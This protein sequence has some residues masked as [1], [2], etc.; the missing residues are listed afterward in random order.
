MS[1]KSSRTVLIMASILTWLLRLLRSTW[2][3]HYFNK[4]L[5][6]SIYTSNKKFLVCF[7]HGK[8]IPVFPLFEGY[9]VTVISNHSMRGE[10]I[11]KISKNFGY[12]VAQLSNQPNHNGFSQMTEILLH[13]R[14][15]ATPV[16]GPSGPYGKVK[17]SIILNAS[18][19]GYDLLPIAVNVHHK[20]MFN[21]RW[22]KLEV[23][24]PFSTVFLVFGEPIHL[25]DDIK[26]DELKAWTDHV[27][28]TMI[29]LD[30]LAKN[31]E[32]RS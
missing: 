15:A 13:S 18:Q 22:D 24:M 20:I 4:D 26:A 5:M 6:E 19:L 17:K 8:Y 7:L 2:S 11:A 30:I 3:V 9:R 31:A 10:I 12:E 23:P 29:H 16:D 27:A 21:K 32:R 1:P 28:S 14:V 25:P